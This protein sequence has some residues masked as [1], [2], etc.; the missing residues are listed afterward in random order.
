MDAKGPQGP[1]SLDSRGITPR[2]D[3]RRIVLANRE[4]KRFLGLP[5]G[6]WRCDSCARRRRRQVMRRLSM[7]LE[8]AKHPRF[9]TLTSPA[10]DS[11]EASLRL[12]SRRFEKL[13]RLVRSG[14]YR[15]EFEFGGV[16]ELTKRGI[17]H[18]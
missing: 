12:L 6:S 8:G 16:V 11:P 1:S 2:S 5:C 13:R 7:G 14:G 17:A 10:G 4:T 18:F 15:G 3:C 9:L